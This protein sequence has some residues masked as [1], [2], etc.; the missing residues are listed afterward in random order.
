VSSQNGNQQTANSRQQQ[1]AGS[2]QKADKKA[3]EQEASP[4]ETSEAFLCF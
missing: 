1:A 4:V 2:T 3:M